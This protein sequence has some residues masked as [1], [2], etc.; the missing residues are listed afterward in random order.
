MSAGIEF[1]LLS[2]ISRMDLKELKQNHHTNVLY[3]EMLKI[4][5]EPNLHQQTES[6]L[7]SR[8]SVTGTYYLIL[9]LVTSCIV[10]SPNDPIF[11]YITTR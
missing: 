10:H 3:N 7:D 1:N 6:E 2:C 5:K 11:V 4:R 9:F 8:G